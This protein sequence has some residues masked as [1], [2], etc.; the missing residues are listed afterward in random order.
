MLQYDWLHY[1]IRNALLKSSNGEWWNVAEFLGKKQRF[2]L[3]LGNKFQQLSKM[4]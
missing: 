4:N 2:Y 3:A 1:T